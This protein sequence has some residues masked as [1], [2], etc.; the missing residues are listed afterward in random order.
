MAAQQQQWVLL[1]APTVTAVA[2]QVT[3]ALGQHSTF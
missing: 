2:M 1:A 3:A